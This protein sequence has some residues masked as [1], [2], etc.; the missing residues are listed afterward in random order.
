MDLKKTFVTTENVVILPGAMVNGDVTLGR[1]CSVWYNAVIRGDVSPIRIGEDTNIQ[2]NAVLHTSYDMPLVL[3]KGVTVGHGAIL[4]SCTVKDN[5][6]IG[7]G[8]IVLDGAVIGRDS[9]VGAG[10]LVTKNTQVPPGSMVLGSP[11]KVKR[12]LTEEEIASIRKN[13]QV[14]LEEKERYR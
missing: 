9:I 3:G 5:V 10:A 2:D 7:M 4:H 11:A 8:A 13:A 6:L 1:G 12:A 14:Y